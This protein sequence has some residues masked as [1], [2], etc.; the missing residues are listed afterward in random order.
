MSDDSESLFV[1]VRLPVGPGNG[2][3]RWPKATLALETP[4][5]GGAPRTGISQARRA[6][7]DE[8]RASIED[9]VCGGIGTKEG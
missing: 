2:S 6:Y 8:K 4:S 7:A 5:Q 1:D 9:A 3:D